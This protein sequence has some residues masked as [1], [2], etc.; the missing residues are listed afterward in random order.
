MSEFLIVFILPVFIL[1]FI[2]LV[3]GGMM[4]Y[5]FRQKPFWYTHIKHEYYQDE[6][7]YTRLRTIK[8]RKKW[9]EDRESLST[10]K[11]AQEVEK[12]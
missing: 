7:G 1:G 10:N 5:G 11:N 8:T 4:K 9:P 3:F 12:Q 2:F 6:E